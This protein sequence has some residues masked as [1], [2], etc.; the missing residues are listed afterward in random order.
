MIRSMTGFGE[1]TVEMDGVHFY[2]EVRSLNAKY[3]KAT[4]RLPDDLQGLEAELEP[5]LRRRLHRG[6]IMVSCKCTDVSAEAAFEINHQA[7][8]RYIA[9]IKSAPSISGADVR[10]DAGALLNLPGVLQQPPDEEDR[11][12][13]ASTAFAQLLERACE[14]VNERREREGELLQADLES[15]RQVIVERLTVIE[16]RAPL[17]VDDYQ[18]RLRTRIDQLLKESA[19]KVDQTDLIREI[20]VY[21]EKTDIAEEISRL[22]GHLEQFEEMI[23]PSQEASIGRTLD[24]LAQEMLRE[25]NTMASKSNDVE[26]SRAVVEIKGAIDRIKEQ[27]QNVE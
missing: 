3:F 20:A 15:L 19:I 16:K 21:A 25:A 12:A 9:Q 10:I 27:V 2:L 23:S 26:I 7:L 6:S 8:E 11:L 13:R 17:V 1:A 22:R 14:Q 5:E 18:Q 24:F 4:V